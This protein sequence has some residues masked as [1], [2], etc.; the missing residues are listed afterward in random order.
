MKYPCEECLVKACCHLYCDDY[1]MFINY[2]ADRLMAMSIK[3]LQEFRKT[4]P[5]EVKQK[6]EH[7]VGNNKRYEIA[8]DKT[9][10]I[11]S[12]KDIFGI[13]E[14]RGKYEIPM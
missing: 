6:I 13:Y 4:L 8:R 12:G 14:E 11:V 3:E 1:Y 5:A 2:K 10:I 7:F 9:C